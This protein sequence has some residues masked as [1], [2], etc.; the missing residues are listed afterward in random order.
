MVE[1]FDS[2]ELKKEHNT[3]RPD[4]GRALRGTLR[5]GIRRFVKSSIT[6]PVLL[7]NISMPKT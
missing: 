3:I 1:K 4:V 7:E 2:R 6:F 5:V